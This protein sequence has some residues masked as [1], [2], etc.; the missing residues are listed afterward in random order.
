MSGSDHAPIR[1]YQR[2]FRPDRRIYQIEGQRLPVPG[3]V[4]L[5]W[6]GYA[7]GAL[8]AVL[9]VSTRSL[10]LSFL[11]GTLLAG[12]GL[13]LGDGLT[14]AFA[15]AGAVG[16]AQLL[17]WMLIMLDWPLR[18]VVMP[19]LVA[20]LATQATPDG[21]APWRFA[22]SWVALQLR[23]ARHSHGRTLPPCE[24]R[25]DL[26]GVVPVAP[27]WR[28]PELRRARIEGPAVVRFTTA[29]LVDR[30]G[31]RGRVLRARARARERAKA[32]R[33]EMVLTN[34]VE[35]I[36]GETLELRP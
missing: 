22:L 26:A 5:R 7:L 15:G 3:G 14:A 13:R 4:P 16:A 2:I 28:A 10:P 30:R 8:V 32:A 19:A 36:A 17:G 31:R 24:E 34:R 25:R 21:R 35:L 23:P 1:S 29:V 9:A 12:Y 18:L 27:D 11:L 6:L 33:R 20:T